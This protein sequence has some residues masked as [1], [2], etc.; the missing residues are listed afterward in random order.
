MSEKKRFQYSKENLKEALAAIKNGMS[1][2]TASKKY[3]IPRST[4]HNKMKS[5]HPDKKPGPETILTHNEEASLVQWIHDCS[6]NLL[7]VYKDHL[8]NSVALMVKLMDR[9]NPFSNGRPGRHW[10]QNFLKRQFSVTEKILENYQ[11]ARAQAT[12]SGVQ[13]WFEHARNFLYNKKLDN[14]DLS[15]VFV[16]ETIALQNPVANQNVEH[17]YVQVTC[18]ASGQVAPILIAYEKLTKKIQDNMPAGWVNC[19]SESGKITAE[20]FYYFITKDFHKWI[21]EKQIQLPI[22]LFLEGKCSLLTMPLSH[23]CKKNKIEIASLPPN[24][25]QV[26]QPLEVGL[27]PHI[28]SAWIKALES[29]RAGNTFIS[30]I[31]STNVYTTAVLGEVLAPLLKWT[32]DSI[33]IDFIIKTAFSTCG[34]YPLRENLVNYEKLPKKT[35]DKKPPVEKIEFDSYVN[36]EDSMKDITSEEFL[37]FFEAN[38]EPEKLKAFK[39]IKDGEDWCGRLDDTSLFYFWRKIVNQCK[40][41]KSNNFNTHQL[42]EDVSL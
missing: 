33:Q 29:Y 26:L 5:K 18:N 13:K 34:L 22:L 42:K 31:P 14:V 17:V 11:N 15:R 37:K 8:L 20:N 10:Y 1:K 16:S 7:P 25:G 41:S 30:I 4:L 38:I 36:N 3:H 24:C 21:E 35:I 39:K 19:K 32:F 2:N 12:Q 40:E 9:D 28:K 23:Y 27:F 6:S